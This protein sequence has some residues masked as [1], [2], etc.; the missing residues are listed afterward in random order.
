MTAPPTLTTRVPDTRDTPLR[1]L[2]A[3]NPPPTEPDTPAPVSSFNAF[4]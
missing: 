3:T 4:I 1:H 2:A